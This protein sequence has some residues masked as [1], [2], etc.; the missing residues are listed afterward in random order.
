MDPLVS[1]IIP[2]HNAEQYVTHCLKSA[3]EQ[4]WKNIEII[5]INDGST[6]S[7]LEKIT[8]FSDP[9]M[10]V[11]NQSQMGAS[12]ARNTGIKNAK[13]VFLQFLDADDIIAREKIE[14]QVKSLM[15]KSSPEENLSVCNT[16]FFQKDIH[17]DYSLDEYNK[18]F[19]A[20]KGSQHAF[21]LNLYGGNGPAGMVQPNAWL[22]PAKVIRSSGLWNESL[23][24]DDDGEFFCRVVLAAKGIIHVDEN[25]NYYRKHQD[26][27][28][29][30]FINSE[31]K[32]ISALKAAQLK[33]D[34][35]IKYVNH[36]TYKLAFGRQFS[37]IEI[38]A[39]PKYFKIYREAR[40]SRKAINAP[41]VLSDMGGRLAKISEKIFGWKFTKLLLYLKQNM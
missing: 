16:V 33:A 40:A 19:L 18:P 35:L 24:L 9:R 31:R 6:D 4:S 29:L 7:S 36:R 21:L 23:S 37:Q 39:F 15:T 12:H 26:G 22:V 1:I 27:K 38:I 5:I 10:K 8:S 34:H 20:F 2:V 32:M 25:L 11:I 17:T 3:I 30:A 41:F 28:N 13:G 14:K